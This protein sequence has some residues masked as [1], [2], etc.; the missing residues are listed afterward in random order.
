MNYVQ[1]TTNKQREKQK[2]K[3]RNHSVHGPESF[4][5]KPRLLQLVKKFPAFYATRRFIAAFTR[6]W[7]LSASYAI[8][9]H[10]APHIR[11]IED[12][13]FP[14]YVWVFPNGVFPPDCHTK[15]CTQISSPSHVLH[16]PPN[17]LFLISSPEMY[18]V[19]STNHEAPHYAVSS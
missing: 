12:P 17:S 11:F 18:L 10:S 8:P 2:I 16:A 6:A 15:P 5:E 7:S 13:Y 9:I 19:R 14:I 3:G 1:I 4:L